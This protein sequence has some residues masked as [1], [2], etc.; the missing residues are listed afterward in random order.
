[1][2][3]EY[4][5]FKNFFLTAHKKGVESAIEDS[6]RS[7]IPLVIEKEG[8]IIHVKPQY[9]YIKVPIDTDLDAAVN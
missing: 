6:I 9:K 8:K 2:N 7:G 3:N 5:S 1:M 4:L